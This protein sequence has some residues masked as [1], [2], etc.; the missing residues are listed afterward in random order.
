MQSSPLPVASSLL[1]PNILRSI[2]CVCVCIHGCVCV[3]ICISV[4]LAIRRQLR[5]SKTMFCRN[6]GSWCVTYKSG[7]MVQGM[8]HSTVNNG[9][10]SRTLQIVRCICQEMAG[11]LPVSLIMFTCYVQGRR[12]GLRA[13]YSVRATKSVHTCKRNCLSVTWCGSSARS[14]LCHFTSV[15]NATAKPRRLVHSSLWHSGYWV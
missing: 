12:A 8:Y 1:G 15:T 7:S 14:S 3:R 13:M 2:L 9:L 5:H 10:V 11:H 4:S 6:H